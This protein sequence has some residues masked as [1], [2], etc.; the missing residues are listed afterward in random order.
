MSRPTIAEINLQ[1][2]KNNVKKLKKIST[3]KLYP[4]VKANA[5]G[6]GLK[7]VIKTINNLVSGFCVATFEEAIELKKLT[8]KS[9]LCMEGPYDLK[10]LN[11]FEKIVSLVLIVISLS[12]LNIQNLGIIRNVFVFK[13]ISM[14]LYFSSITLR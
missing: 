3:S 6:H 11:I 4:V 9:V 12:D 8:T 5:Y 7:Q 14:K 10:E 2:L 13:L 1:A